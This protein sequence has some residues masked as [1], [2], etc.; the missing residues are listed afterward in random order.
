MREILAIIRPN[1][2]TETR[3]AGR[4]GEQGK[5]EETA[6]LLIWQKQTLFLQKRTK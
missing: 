3:T 6:P 2:L 1:K 5:G 4:E